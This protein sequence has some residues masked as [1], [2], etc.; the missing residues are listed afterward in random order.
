MTLF[1]ILA[2]SLVGVLTGHALR[3]MTPWLAGVK[4]SEVPFSWPWLEILAALACV[5]V[6]VDTE[7]GPWFPFALLLLAV[8]ATDFHVK[9][10]PNRITFPGTAIGLL[11]STVAWNDICGFL[12]HAD[13]LDAFGL[14]AGAMGGLVLAILGAA[15]GFGL[16]EGFRRLIGRLVG[17]EVMGM[18]DSKLL[19][20]A[21]A[22]LGP[23]MV[24]LSLVPAMLCGLVLGLVYTRLAGTPHLPFGPALALGAFLTLFFGQDILDLWVGLGEAIRSLPR[25]ANLVVMAVL[26]VIAILLLRRVRRRR[27]EYSRKIEEEYDK[28][29]ERED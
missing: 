3:R 28:L 12:N 7:R 26:F 19:M 10:I 2:W 13:L 23:S 5:A 15:V 21:G 14:S 18:G 25:G 8:T 20:M 24:L 11:L 6:S 9:L 29:E 22:F 4:G 1:W 17:M 16:L 27:A